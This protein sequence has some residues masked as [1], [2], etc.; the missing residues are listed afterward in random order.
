MGKLD[1][2]DNSVPVFHML[3][4]RNVKVVLNKNQTEQNK[5]TN[6]PDPKNS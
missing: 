1:L 6:K 4:C 5:Q 2:E 3:F